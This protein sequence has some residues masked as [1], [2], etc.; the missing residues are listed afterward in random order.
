[1]IK[2]FPRRCHRTMMMR[3]FPLLPFG[4]VGGFF[5]TFAVAAEEALPPCHS[6]A[7]AARHCPSELLIIPL[8]KGRAGPGDHP[9]PLCSVAA[10]G[11]V[12]RWTQYASRWPGQLLIPTLTRPR[13]LCKMRSCAHANNQAGEHDSIFRPPGS[14]AEQDRSGHWTDTDTVRGGTSDCAM[15][16]WNWRK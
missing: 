3:S 16:Q 14:R 10:R 4:E 5:F 12:L 13:T 7:Q 9:P 15:Q 2:L 1:M 6:P 8:E 11:G